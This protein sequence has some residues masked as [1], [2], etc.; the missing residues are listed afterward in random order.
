LGRNIIEEETNQ[1]SKLLFDGNERKK[2]ELIE[3]YSMMYL[4]KENIKMF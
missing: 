2:Y 4:K 3:N 1:K